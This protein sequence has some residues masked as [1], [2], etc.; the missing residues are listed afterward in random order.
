LGHYWDEK[1]NTFVPYQAD[2]PSFFSP[3][4]YMHVNMDD[5][6]KFILIHMD[7]YP[8]QKERLIEPGTLDR[9]HD[10]PDKV[11]WDIDIDLGLNY[12]IGWFTKTD[13][14]GHKLIWHG[15]RGFDFNA[16]VVVDLNDKNAILVV[17]TSELPNVHPQ[18]QLL[19]ITKKI[20][21]SY[22]NKFD[23]PSII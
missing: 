9:L 1:S 22:K 11:R 20:K 7:L 13:K 14:D 2:F 5:W 10:P 17:S 19:K 8:A 3:A 15:G 21:E 6:A 23:L 4:G 18:T 12:A 16:Q